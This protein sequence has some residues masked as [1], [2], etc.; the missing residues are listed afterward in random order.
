MKK[1]NT[2]D[3]LFQRARVL[4]LASLLTLLAG[5]STVRFT[6]HHGDTLL[7]WWLDS[8]VDLDSD[9]A[10]WVKQDIDRFFQWHRTTQLRD[11][12]GLMT[13]WQG[14]LAGKLTQADLVSDYA[15][16]KERAERMAWQ[17]LPDMADL[18]RSLKPEQIV[19]L[20]KKFKSN[21]EKF[22]DK[23]MSGDIEDQHKARFKKDLT[24]LVILFGSFSDEQE[25]ALRRASD[26]R[27]LNNDVWL[28]ERMLR[29]KKIIALLQ[30]VQQEK[31]N[32][33]QTMAAIRSL[34]QQFFDRPEAPERK[35][36]YDAY[37]DS[38]SKFVLTV[39]SITT[40]QQRAHAQQRLQGW[41]EDCNALA[42]ERP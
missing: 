31:L 41:I 18:A 4:L 36:F 16:V 23:F 5:C 30:R 10:T 27:P 12:A 7:Y 21:N 34:L 6:Y 38:T 35:A 42:S 20:Q 17:A 32:K 11:Y 22:R 24:Q 33:D 29:Q 3:T 37:T 14:Q 13:T 28:D 25:A 8:Y 26:A 2:P 19:H 40:A 15:A 39:M 9:Q 1:F